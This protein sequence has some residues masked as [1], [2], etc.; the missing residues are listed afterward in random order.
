MLRNVFFSVSKTSNKPRPKGR[1]K[2]QE[3]FDVEVFD[4]PRTLVCGTLRASK[5]PKQTSA[6][7]PRYT[8]ELFDIQK[9]SYIYKFIT[10][11]LKTLNL[12]FLKWNLKTKL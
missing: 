2:T 1:G 3:I 4:K 8:Q 10:I 9:N 12:L 6:F 11:I 5:S 7:K